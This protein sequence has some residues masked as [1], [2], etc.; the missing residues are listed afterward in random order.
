MYICRTFFKR[1]K[2][3]IDSFHRTNCALYD[4]QFQ[5]VKN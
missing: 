2:I 1:S 3:I 5:N 4:G